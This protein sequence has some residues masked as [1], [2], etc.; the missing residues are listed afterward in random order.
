MLQ[1]VED[2]LEILPL[3]KAE[4]AFTFLEKYALGLV[5]HRAPA[6]CRLSTL[7]PSL[8]PTLRNVAAWSKAPF[9]ERAPRTRMLRLANGRPG[10]RCH[11]AII[12][13][14]LF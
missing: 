12:P 1:L 6:A 7:L 9:S 13:S 3:S 4:L 5:P 14:P 8:F 10:G 2:A 11:L